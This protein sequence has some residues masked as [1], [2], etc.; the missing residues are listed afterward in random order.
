MKRPSC[1]KCKGALIPELELGGRAISIGCVNC[2]FR[3]F[4][5]HKTRHPNDL[6]KNTN[7]VPHK[8]SS[9]G[10]LGR[11]NYRAGLHRGIER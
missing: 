11:S 3:V 2:G 5:S 1:P 10:N 9:R 4:R 6:E 7:A 8:T